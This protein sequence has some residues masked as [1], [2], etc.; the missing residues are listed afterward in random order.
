MRRVR[1]YHAVKYLFALGKV[2]RIESNLVAHV[3]YV[4]Y[5]T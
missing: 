5:A 4:R 3:L 1:T 2:A